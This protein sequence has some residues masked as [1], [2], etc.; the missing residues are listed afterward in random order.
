MGSRLS[1]VAMSGDTD[2]KSKYRR[3]LIVAQAPSSRSDPSEPLSGQS[4]RRLAAL[5][6][7]QGVTKP[8]GRKPRESPD[9]YLRVVAGLLPREVEID[10]GRI[11]NGAELG[12]GKRD[13][14]HAAGPRAAGNPRHTRFGVLEQNSGA[15]SQAVS[16]RRSRL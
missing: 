4:G 7:R 5:V 10:A 16:G 8:G 6:G 9:I 14:R 15:E 13:R 1:P 12:V 3:P 11:K 2:P